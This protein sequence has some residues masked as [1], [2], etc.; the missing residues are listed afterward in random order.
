MQDVPGVS[1][2]T[3]SRD[4]DGMIRATLA[5]AKAEEINTVLLALQAAGFTITAN[6]SQD[7]GERVLADITVRS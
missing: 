1:L 5:A 3:L 6:P 7:A 4:P 2:T